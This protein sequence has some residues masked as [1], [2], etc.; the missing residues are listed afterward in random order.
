[1][2]I[3]RTYPKGMCKLNHM[4]RR[5]QEQNFRVEIFSALVSRNSENKTPLHIAIENN[6]LW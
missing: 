4:L 2:T 3:S 5:S 6:C 1:M